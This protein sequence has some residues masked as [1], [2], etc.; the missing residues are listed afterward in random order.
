MILDLALVDPNTAVTLT[1][2]ESGSVTF[3][4]VELP[5]RK[6]RFKWGGFHQT[7]FALA[8]RTTRVASMPESG[9]CEVYDLETRRVTTHP[10]G[11]TGQLLLA[12]GGR[13]LARLTRNQ[14]FLWNLD[15]GVLASILEDQP[16]LCGTRRP[17]F[18]SDGRLLL[19][20]THEGPWQA[21]DS[22]TGGL[23]KT[24]VGDLVVAVQRDQIAV[25]GD[26]SVLGDLLASEG[27]LWVDELPG[28]VL[29]RKSLWQ[30]EEIQVRGTPFLGSNE[31]VSMPM[32]NKHRLWDHHSRCGSVQ[33]PSCL[34]TED[35]ELRWW[36]LG[37]DPQRRGR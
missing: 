32:L 10:E 21:L 28:L 6:A 3:A 2:A 5:T 34:W 17:R 29:T 9:A 26:G 22:G 36:T 25:S 19:R 14:V 30:V 33:G 1:Q 35:G 4:L 27:P 8:P 11:E 31:V 13:W 37:K 16:D 12:P 18:S 24:L 15:T 7:A 20:P 23:R